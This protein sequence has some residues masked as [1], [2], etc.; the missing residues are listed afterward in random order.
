MNIYSHYSASG[1]KLE[2]FPF[3]AELA[4]EGYLVE[5]PEILKLSDDTDDDGIQIIEIEKEWKKKE[6][7]RGRIDLLVSYGDSAYAIVELKNDVLTSEAFAQLKDYFEDET[8]LKAVS[9]SLFDS[10]ELESKEANKFQWLGV[11]VGT[12]ISA[13]L[14]AEIE[15]YNSNTDK[16]FAVIILNRYKS[17]NQ[18]FTHT[19]IAVRPKKSRDHSV[20]VFNGGKYKK[21]R[22]VLAMIQ[23]YAEKNFGRLTAPDLMGLLSLSGKPIHIGGKPILINYDDA[24]NDSKRPNANGNAYRYYFIK[25]EEAVVFDGGIKLAVLD[26]WTKNDRHVIEKI[27]KALDYNFSNPA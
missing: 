18:I 13:E 22:L 11:L 2:P 20:Y 3:I 19:D 5:N 17:G 27:A 9:K 12:G 1:S 16:P 25:P 15:K 24:V 14:K 10:F 6:E 4:M 21:G 23:S 7:G 26:W 8:H